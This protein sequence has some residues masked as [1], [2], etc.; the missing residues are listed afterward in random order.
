MPLKKPRSPQYAITTSVIHWDRFRLVLPGAAEWWKSLRWV[1]LVFTF[2]I[3]L[4][5]IGSFVSYERVVRE[6]HPWLSSRHCPG[7]LL[8]G[9]TKSFCAMSSGQWQ[10]ASEWNRSGPAVYMF[11]WL[12]LFLSI[13]NALV[14]ARS[15][16]RH[17]G[18]R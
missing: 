17:V 12:W 8:C 6:G 13:F 9:M 5:L 7:C 18:L 2:L 4:T 14:G 10:Q 1:L 11:F 3:A 15:S 16:R